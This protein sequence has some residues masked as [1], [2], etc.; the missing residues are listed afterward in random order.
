MSRVLLLSI[1]E[2]EVVTKCLAAK[3]RISAIEALPS[4]GTRLVCMSVDG[5]DRMRRKLKPKLI[6][7]AVS[8]HLYRPGMPP[9]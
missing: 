2:G 4:G 5:A 8:R 3:V 7:G 6:A 9:L 1:D